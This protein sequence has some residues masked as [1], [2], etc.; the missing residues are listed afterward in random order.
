MAGTANT[1]CKVEATKA[2][3]KVC[4]IDNTSVYYHYMFN[5]WWEIPWLP[6]IVSAVLLAVA[7]V[8]GMFY[9]WQK[10]REE[11]YEIWETFDGLVYSALAALLAARLGY[12]ILHLNSFP[13]RLG[14]VLQFWEFPGMWSPA[15]L[16]AAL[17]TMAWIAIRQKKDTYELLDFYVIFLSWFLGWYWLS[18]FAVGTAAGSSTQLPWGLMFP[19]RVEAAH[20]VQ[21]YSFIIFSLLFKY[22]WWAEPRYRFFIWYRSKKRTARSGF[23]LAV[24]LI[25]VGLLGVGLGFVRY[26]S[27]MFMDFNLNQLFYAIMF[28][29]GWIILISRSGR[30]FLLKKEKGKYVASFPTTDPGVETT[31]PGEGSQ[32][33]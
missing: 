25:S 15:G 12:V 9:F 20:P 7:V 23:L 30:T 27:L 28:T 21:I 3:V 11:H 2:P 24:F 6:V 18:R 32:P 10:I 5:W 1:G 13:L 14:A 16:L 26:S 33:S 17:L 22:L 19:Q 8:G 4:E 31:S 29:L